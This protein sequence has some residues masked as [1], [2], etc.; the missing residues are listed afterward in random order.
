MSWQI[1]DAYGFIS[2]FSSSHGL[3][4]VGSYLETKGRVF[5]E[6]F[7]NMYTFD[8]VTLRKAL[9]K[10]PSS[11]DKMIDSKIAS[12]LELSRRCRYI[13]IFNDGANNWIDTHCT[14]KNCGLDLFDEFEFQNINTAK[15]PDL[16]GVYAIKIRKWGRDE[17]DIG[18]NLFEFFKPLRWRM[19]QDYFY[20]Y[21]GRIQEINDCPILYIGHAGTNKKSRQTLAVSYHDLAYNHPNQFPLWALLHNGWQLDFGWMVHDRPKKYATELK[22][23]YTTYHG[24]MPLLTWREKQ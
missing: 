16:P 7:T 22:V 11:G 2:D 15:P 8:L 21:L 17:I 1:D 6:L 13:L 20:H 24:T 19:M 10:V 23:Q 5:R 18:N 3:V 9:K 4:E 12:L 14:K